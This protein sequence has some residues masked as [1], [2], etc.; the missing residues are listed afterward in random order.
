MVVTELKGV[1]TSAKRTFFEAGDAGKRCTVAIGG[2]DG[3]IELIEE[4]EA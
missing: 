2:S 1:V 3:A 4:G